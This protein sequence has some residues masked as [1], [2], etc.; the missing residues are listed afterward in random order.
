LN[1][2]ERSNVLKQL[3]FLPA[4]GFWCLLNTGCGNSAG[5]YPVSGKVLFRGEPAGGAVVFFHREGDAGGMEQQIPHA[6]VEDDGSFSLATDELGDGARPGKYL[7]LV[8]WRDKSGNGIVPVNT[9]GTTKLV[10]R[11]RIHSGP[12]RLKG[13]YLDITKPL[14]HAEVKPET[15]RLAPFELVN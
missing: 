7:V 12:D 15:N 8:E 13:R 1:G 3:V 6:V 14:L 2:K 10:K 11:I 5:V 4:L 9:R